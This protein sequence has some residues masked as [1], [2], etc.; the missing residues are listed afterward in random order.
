MPSLD[1]LLNLLQRLAYLLVESIHQGRRRGV[2]DEADLV[3]RVL[4]L[5][6]ATDVIRAPSFLNLKLLDVFSLFDTLSTGPDQ[7]TF[8]L[9]R[10]IVQVRL[11]SLV[12]IFLFVDLQLFDRDACHVEILR[13]LIF[14]LH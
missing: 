5:S 2:S 7:A 6:L 8:V 12:H 14:V 10:L 1:K 11:V 4:H 9:D 13:Y 3:L